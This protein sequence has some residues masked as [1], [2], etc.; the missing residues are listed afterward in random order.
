M[1]VISSWSYLAFSLVA[2]DVKHLFMCL[3]AIYV[4]SS[5]KYLFRNFAHYPIRFFLTIEFWDFFTYP[6]PSPFYRI[7]SLQI[8][9]QSIAYV[10][11]VLAESFTEQKFL[12]LM[13]SSLSVFSFYESCFGVMSKNSSLRHKSWIYSLCYLLKL[14]FALYI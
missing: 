4:S 6:R 3:F 10:F 1:C 9:S 8:F 5:V 7:C 12:V 14:C 2:N 11:I 13:R